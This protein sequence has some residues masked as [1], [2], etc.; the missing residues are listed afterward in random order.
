VI[1]AVETLKSSIFQEFQ[2]SLAEVIKYG[3]IRDPELFN[4]LED[5]VEWFFSSLRSGKFKDEVF[6]FLEA[7]VW[8]SAKIKAEVVERDE[9]E[10]KG[11]RMILNYGHTFA[12]AL[13]AASGYRL[14]HGEAV[15]IGMALAG[16]LAVRLKMFHP[17]DQIRQLNLIR[18][19]GLPVLIPKGKP[20]SSDYLFNFMKRDKKVRHGKLRFVLPRRIGRAEVRDGISET[21]MKRL[22]DESC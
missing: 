9:R 11:G 2:S 5:K 16:K 19:A 21:E 8:R 14:P 13:E 22:L 18:R 10:T 12:H 15:A 20:F 1:S 6:S 17:E 3:V 7:V 4:L